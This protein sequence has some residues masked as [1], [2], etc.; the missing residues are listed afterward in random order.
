MLGRP[1]LLH[2]E[3]FSKTSARVHHY[4][5]LY[6]IVS[7]Q[8]AR[9]TTAEWHELLDE[10]EIPNGPMRSLQELL[11]DPYLRDTGFFHRYEHPTEGSAVTTSV[12]TYF[13]RSP[14]GLRLPPPRLGEHN[15][16]VL[17]TLGYTEAEIAQLIAD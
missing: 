17:G 12:P 8:L 11:N 4:D 14:G 3:R 9:R 15:A 16:E 7:D 5:E 10:I 2:D 1:E 6:G 13:S